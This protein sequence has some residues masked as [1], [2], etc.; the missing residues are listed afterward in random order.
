MDEEL[1]AF[2]KADQEPF[3]IATPIVHLLNQGLLEHIENAGGY[4]AIVLKNY[5]EFMNFAQQLPIDQPNLAM[6]LRKVSPVLN[7]LNVKYYIVE[8]GM[9]IDGPRVDLVFHGR[10]YNL[11]RNNAA[12]PRSFVVHDVRIINER[13]GAFRLI[14][15][16]ESAPRS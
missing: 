7:L 2:L 8:S 5:N 1:K 6:R 11:Y 13:D 10:K 3:R 14:A 15:S 16:A 12:L 4:D 9:S